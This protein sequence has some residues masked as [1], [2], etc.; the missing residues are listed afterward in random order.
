M[1]LCSI[2]AEPASVVAHTTRIHPAYRGGG[3]PSHRGD[4]KW[5]GGILISTLFAYI[6]VTRTSTKRQ[7]RREAG[8][9]SHGPLPRGALGDGGQATERK[10]AVHPI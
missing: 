8:M 10:D 1:L 3:A 9:Q 2:Q 6:V 4:K 7:T 5:P